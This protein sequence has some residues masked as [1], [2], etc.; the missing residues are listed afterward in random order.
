MSPTVSTATAAPATSVRRSA[1]VWVIVALVLIAT[2]GATALLTR[3]SPAEFLDP[4]SAAPQGSRALAQILADRGD[5]V[6]TVTSLSDTLAASQAHTVV[7]RNDVIVTSEAAER[8]TGSVRENGQRLV[9]LGVQGALLQDRWAA[10]TVPDESALAADCTLAA[11]D[12]A[13]TATFTELVEPQTAQATPGWE[14]V[15]FTQGS[16][17]GLLAQD[18]TFLLS[19]ASAFTNAELEQVGNAALGINVLSGAGTDDTVGDG[20][21]VWYLPSASDPALAAPGSASLN[22][23]LPVWLPAVLLMILLG[24]IVLALWRGRRL[25][26]LLSEDLPVL[27]Q[28]Y[29]TEVGRANLMQR[30]HDRNGA[31][32]ALRAQAREHLIRTTGVPHAATD[33]GALAATQDVTA[34]VTSGPVGSDSELLLLAERLARIVGPGPGD[35]PQS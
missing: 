31:A 26:P 19:D 9:V 5:S 16:A 2:I 33:A 1:K 32:E 34:A 29:E 11:A 21:I 25:G 24:S 3:P 22:Q 30:N 14:Q 18:Q 17:A 15:C 6:Q 28:S 4:R 12:A 27:V 20:Q 7:V 8:L 23:V 13:G 10:S 35:E